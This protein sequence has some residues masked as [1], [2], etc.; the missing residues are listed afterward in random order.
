MKRKLLAAVS[1]HCILSI[2]LHFLVV[3]AQSVL[4]ELVV[5]TWEIL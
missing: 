2:K 1:E 3:T 5:G 4:E